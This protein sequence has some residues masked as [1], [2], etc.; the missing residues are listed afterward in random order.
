[1]PTLDP[2][3][4]AYI[5]RSAP[6]AQP[7]LI[8]LRKL[9]HKACPDVVETLKWSMPFFEYKGPLC[10]M[11]AFKQHCAFGF[12]KQKLIDH[13]FPKSEDAMSSFGRITAI[14]DLP[15]DKILTA[16]IK[17]AAKLNEAGVKLERKPKADRGEIVVPTILSDAL[18]K[19]AA[20]KKTFDNFP[21]SK[22]RDYVEW[23][24]DAKTDAT[25]EKRLATTIEQLA[26]GKSKNWKYE[27]KKK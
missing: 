17:E 25:R 27:T 10:N 20:A 9:I 11:A 8:H 26:E 5:E 6:F 2:R 4:D 19:N 15:S 16:L 14:K 22:K 1:M 24:E 18:K 12:W 23:I 3:T 7:I 13:L 21:P